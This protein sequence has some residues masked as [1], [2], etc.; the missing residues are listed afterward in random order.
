MPRV[1]QISPLRTKI[2]KDQRVRNESSTEV[3]CFIESHRAIIVAQGREFL[4]GD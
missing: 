2:S 3:I 4:A 1:K